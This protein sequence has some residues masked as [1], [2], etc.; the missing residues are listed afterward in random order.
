MAS[1]KESHHLTHSNLDAN[2]EAITIGSPLDGTKNP[3]TTKLGDSL[4][5]ITGV[6]TYAFGFYRILPLTAIKVTASV[7]PALPPVT[8]ITSTG[9][10]RGVTVGDYNVENLSANSS[11]M[12]AIASHIAKYLKSPDLMFLQEVQ[13]NNGATDNGGKLKFH[14]PTA[15]HTD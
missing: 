5:D 4:T 8:S 15:S 10:C 2:P 14:F 7:S 13:D 1:F 12:P 11:H 9:S 6:V 3:T